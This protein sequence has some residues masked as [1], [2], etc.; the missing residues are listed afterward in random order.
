MLMVQR[1]LDVGELAARRRV[2]GL[3]AL[4]GHIACPWNIVRL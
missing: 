3:E 1:P 2:Q 4:I